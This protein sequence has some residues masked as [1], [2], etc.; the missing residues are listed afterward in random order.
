VYKIMDKNNYGV[1]KDIEKL[2]NRQYEV[3]GD[4]DLISQLAKLR[5]ELIQYDA[6]TNIATT[7]CPENLQ[8]VINNTNRFKN[9]QFIFVIS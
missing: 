6:A 2:Y 8:I 9:Y 1:I 3:I 4:R 5:P 7:N